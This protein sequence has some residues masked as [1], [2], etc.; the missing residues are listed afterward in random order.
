MQRMERFAT[1]VYRKQARALGK[2]AMADKLQNASDNEREH[3]DTLRKRL[4]ELKGTPSRTGT[5][6]DIAGAILG[7]KTA[8]IGKL[9]LLKTDMWIEKRAIRD[10]SNFLRKIDFD[11][12][13]KALIRRIIEDEKKHIETWSISVKDLKGG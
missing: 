13:T 5:L 10:Y 12:E 11:D 6:F 9:F 8:L 7:L 1:Q 2:N 3:A 4:Y